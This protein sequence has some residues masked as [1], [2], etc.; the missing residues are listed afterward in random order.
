MCM[1]TGFTALVPIKHAV[2]N[3]VATVLYSIVVITLEVGFVRFESMDYYTARRKCSYNSEIRA[4]SGSKVSSCPTDPPAVFHPSS[5]QPQTVPRTSESPSQAPRPK[6]RQASAVA[7]TLG[8]PK[9]A[10]IRICTEP[11]S[12]SLSASRAVSCVMCVIAVQWVAARRTLYLGA[13]TLRQ[14]GSLVPRCD[15]ALQV[16]EYT[17]HD[18]IHS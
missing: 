14:E 16:R 9:S 4:V 13:K 2:I 12:G 5:N 6:S 7:G 10:P 17:S 11:R 3:P 8:I 18:T 1:H 15:W